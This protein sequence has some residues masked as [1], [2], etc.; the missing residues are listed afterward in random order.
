M[1][2][3]D[4][5]RPR[6]TIVLTPEHRNRLQ[7]LAAERRERG[8]SNLIR[9]AINVYLAANAAERA[10][11]AGLLALKGSISDEEAEQMRA[12]IMTLR[13]GWRT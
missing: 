8:I 2:R 11:R 3:K 4:G 13:K 6:T 7:E 1:T 10:K 12:T 5:E 9:E